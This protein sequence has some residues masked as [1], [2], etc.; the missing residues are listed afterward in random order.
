MCEQVC[1]RMIVVP[2]GDFG[3]VITGRGRVDLDKPGVIIVVDHVI[4]PI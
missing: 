3:G 2:R 1:E 4:E